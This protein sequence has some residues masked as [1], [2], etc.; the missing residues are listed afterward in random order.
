VE[1]VQHETLT[2]IIFK[3]SS[4]STDHRYYLEIIENFATH[5]SRHHAIYFVCGSRLELKTFRRS[6]SSGG[7]NSY[8]MFVD[9][10]Q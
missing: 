3:S 8:W 1:W 6:I 7:Y 9:E 4:V 2:L 10:L 5:Q